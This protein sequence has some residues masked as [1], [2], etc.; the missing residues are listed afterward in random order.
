[1]PFKNF[2][3]LYKL[4]RKLTG[5]KTF[6]EYQR[7]VANNGARQRAAIMDYVQKRKRGERESQVQGKADLLTLFLQ[8][9]DVFDDELIVDELRDFFEAAMMTTP[10]AS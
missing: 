3:P 1:M 8:R 4:A 9:P 7:V 6:T 5:K 10:Y 2:N